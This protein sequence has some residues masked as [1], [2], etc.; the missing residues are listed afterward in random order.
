MVQDF[1]V[2]IPI[3]IVCIPIVAIVCRFIY[4]DHERH[5]WHETVRLAIEK[6]QAIPPALLE[7]ELEAGAR[8]DPRKAAMGL[9]IGGLVNIG[10]GIG[11]FYGLAHLTGQQRVGWVGVIPAAIGVALLAAALLNLYLFRDSSKSDAAARS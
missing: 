10:A 11:L 7:Q 6:G 5:R 9:L 1:G 8:R 2:L 3:I 4:R